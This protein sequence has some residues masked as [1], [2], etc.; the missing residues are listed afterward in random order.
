MINNARQLSH[1]LVCI[2]HQRE[3]CTNQRFVGCPVL[4]GGLG[5]APPLKSWLSTWRYPQQQ[6]ERLQ[7]IDRY[8]YLL[9]APR[10]RQSCCCA[11]RCILGAVGTYRSKGGCLLVCLSVCL[12]VSLSVCPSGCLSAC[13]PVCLP[14]CWTQPWALQK[15]MIR[16]RCRLGRGLELAQGTIH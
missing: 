7:N 10:L 16:S 14:V 1:S 12:P 11:R 15:R 5:P 4:A 2:Y 9:P 13:L 8:M 3:I 6:F